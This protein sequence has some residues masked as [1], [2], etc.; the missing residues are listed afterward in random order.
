MSFS[1]SKI[2]LYERCPKKYYF[3]YIEKL[4]VP[5]EDKPVFEKGRFIHHI[6][7]HYPELPEFNFKFKEVEDK[8]LDYLNQINEFITKN[9]KAKFF[10]DQNVLLHREK[11][12]FLNEKLEE[13]KTREESIINGII[14]YVGHYNDNIIL[15]DWKTGMSQKYASLNQL[16]FYSLYIFNNFPSINKLKVFLFFVEQDEYIYE[17]LTRTDYKKTEEKYLKLIHTILDD[18]EYKCKKAEDCMRCEYYENC[19]P[20]KINLTKE[21]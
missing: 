12:F 19:K 6:I 9:K 5:F 2:S 4:Q 18:T 21:K 13:V 3:K 15:V 1:Y 17:E 14:D 11:E 7:E 10:L 8:K 20:F 16:K